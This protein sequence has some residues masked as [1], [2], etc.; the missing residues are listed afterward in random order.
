MSLPYV[1]KIDVTPAPAASFTNCGVSWCELYRHARSTPQIR[2]KWA[3][4]PSTWY[5]ETYILDI[6]AANLDEC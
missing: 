5:D 1:L 4:S 6:F 2:K 3:S